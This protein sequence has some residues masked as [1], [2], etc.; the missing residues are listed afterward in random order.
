QTAP[1]G[2]VAFLSNLAEN[3]AG[4]DTAAVVKEMGLGSGTMPDEAAPL[5]RIMNAMTPLQR[6]KLLVL[7]VGELFT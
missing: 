6:E 1:E 3:S 7:F 5:H 2:V 4:V